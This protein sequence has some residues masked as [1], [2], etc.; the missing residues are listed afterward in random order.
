MGWRNGQFFYTKRLLDAIALNYKSIYEGLPLS[1]ANEIYYLHDI[2]EYKVDFDCALKGIG[3]G[4]WRGLTSTKL[5]DYKGFGRAQ[6]VVIASILGIPEYE[7]DFWDILHFRSYAYYLM[8]QY[9]NKEGKL[10]AV[11]DD[12]RS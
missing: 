5:K 3:R 10:N 4:N 7:L 2:V 12:S 11:E 1:W 9:L 8:C 6:Q